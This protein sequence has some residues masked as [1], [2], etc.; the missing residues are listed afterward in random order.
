MHGTNIMNPAGEAFLGI[1]D[2][3]ED[4]LQGLCMDVRPLQSRGWS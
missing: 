1:L 4:P 3:G 2:H